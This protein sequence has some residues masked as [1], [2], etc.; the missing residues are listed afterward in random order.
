MTERERDIEEWLRKRIEVMSGFFWKFTSPGNDGVPDRV[1]M[2]PDGRTVF[3]ELKAAG[4]HLART[5]WYQIARMV[6]KKQQVCVVRGMTGA[7]DFLQ[8]MKE[9]STASIDYGHDG[10]HVPLEILN[11]S[12]SG[13]TAG[14]R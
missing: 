11:E 9:H 4:G 2:F 3:V 5:Q 8:D 7:K 10:K 1:A 12:I 13:R 14:R 6:K